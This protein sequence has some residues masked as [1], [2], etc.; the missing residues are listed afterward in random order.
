MRFADGVAQIHAG[1]DGKDVSLDRGDKHLK[2]VHAD[3]GRDRNDRPDAHDTGKARKD[4][5]HGVTGQKVAAQTHRM[6]Q[7]PYEVRDDLDHGKDRPQHQGAEVTQ[8][9]AR[10]PSPLR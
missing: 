9:I 5:D 8:N 10:K 2:P 7:G 4:L 1:Q 3:D 6:R